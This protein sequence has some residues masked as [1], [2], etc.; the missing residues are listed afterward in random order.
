VFDLTDLA[1]ASSWGKY[2]DPFD[3]G[4]WTP[5]SSGVGDF[6]GVNLGF[7]LKKGASRL[8]ILV[9]TRLV[10]VWIWTGPCI[11]FVLGGC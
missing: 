5:D 3:L 11:G 2:V 1:L 4:G 8:A 7:R 10:C 9:A 6:N